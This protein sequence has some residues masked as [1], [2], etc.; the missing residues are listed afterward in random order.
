VKSPYYANRTLQ[1]IWKSAATAI[2]QAEELVLMGFSLPQ[3]DL[4]MSSM[5]T[6]NLPDDSIIT[7]VDHSPTILQRVCEVFDLG[8]GDSRLTTA[9]AGRGDAALPEWVE[10]FASNVSDW[11]PPELLN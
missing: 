6:T 5:L 1:A 10:E 4:L 11:N 8:E 9:H 3:S 7:P 2:S